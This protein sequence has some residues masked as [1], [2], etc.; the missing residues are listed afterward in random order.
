MA[1][2]LKPEGGTPIPSSAGGSS[3]QSTP[4]TKSEK[5]QHTDPN[6][7][8]TPKVPG[9]GVSAEEL[10]RLRSLNAAQEATLRDY[11]RQ[12]TELV[13]RLRSIDD[14]VKRVETPEPSEAEMNQEFWKNP[15]GVMNRLIKDELNRTVGPLN[16]R[17]SRES[18]MSEYDR[19]KL[20]L[21]EQYSDIWDQISPSIDAFINQATSQGVELNE[22]LMNVAALTA[23]GML[24]RGQ[25][26]GVSPVKKEEPNPTKE[27][28]KPATVFTP[29]HLRP[30][31]PMIPGAEPEKKEHRQL[32]ENERRIARERRLTDEQYLAWLD[33][34]PEEVVRS[35][36]G[37][38]EGK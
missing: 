31:A 38:E 35:R 20:K 7:D 29:P 9:A 33:V 32:S 17:L 6:V 21:K 11:H 30:S 26:P 2:S 13:Q 15:T 23:S 14:R 19:A 27:E 8:T 16:E 5:D 37:K 25:I 24:Y 4:P 18:A 3:S 36:I 22:Q 12:N 28:G 10:E 34:P 1:A